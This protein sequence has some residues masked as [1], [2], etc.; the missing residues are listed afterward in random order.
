VSFFTDHTSHPQ[1]NTD[2]TM[3]L[4]MMILYT[5]SRSE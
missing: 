5:S 4:K 2:T 3:A 1:S